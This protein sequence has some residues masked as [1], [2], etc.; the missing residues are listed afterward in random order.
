LSIDVKTSSDKIAF[1]IVKGC[2]SKDDYP[3]GNAESSWEKLKNKFEPV[4]APATVKLDKQ[5]RESSLKKGQEP[6]VWIKD[7]FCRQN[8]KK[9]TH[10]CE[11]FRSFHST[12]HLWSMSKS[13][14]LSLE[15]LSTLM[16]S[17]DLS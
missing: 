9:L 17:H 10:D 8:A 14:V 2:K 4:C 15:Y 1:N 11:L 5:F 6:E 3:D 13:A 12:K 16:H 7:A